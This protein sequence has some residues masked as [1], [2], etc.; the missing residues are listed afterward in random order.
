LIRLRFL[1][2]ALGL[3]V[4]PALAGT[5]ARATA[6]PKLTATPSGRLRVSATARYRAANWKGRGKARRDRVTVTIAVARKMLASGPYRGSEVFRTVIRH[7]L[8][9][10][11][12][13]RRYSVLLPA[14]A[15]RLLIKWGALSSHLHRRAQARRAR[16]G[17][18]NTGGG[19]FV[20][21]FATVGE[22][23][24]AASYETLSVCSTTEASTCEELDSTGT[25]KI[26][27]D[28]IAAT[29][30]EFASQP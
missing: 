4:V 22:R 27:I 26:T 1:L 3:A 15:S 12:V 2:L 25:S 5:L 24:Y 6:L 17:A 14:K 11:Q 13:K 21:R 30:E 20:Q 8:R 9:H 7:Q 29:G 28:S 19:G 10:R 16:S 18:A 23:L